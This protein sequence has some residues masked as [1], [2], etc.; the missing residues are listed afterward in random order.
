MKQDL[1]DTTG[2]KQGSVVLPDELF[3][4]K[5][6]SDL[7][8]RYIR[9]FLSRN[10]QAT[11]QTKRR[12][13]LSGTTAKIW[14]QKGTGKA[15]HGS[16]KASI[17]VGGAKAH[18]PTGQENYQLKFS[19]K[20]KKQA[21]ASSLSAM[22]PQTKIIKGL[23]QVSKTTKTIQQALENLQ[24]LTPG[25]LTTIILSNSSSPIIKVTS[26]LDNVI[27]TQAHRVNPYEILNCQHLI[28]T[29][30]SLETLTKTFSAKKPVQP[31]KVTAKKS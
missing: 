27:T 23:D 12:N 11:K 9:I 30:E 13:Q 16:R 10:R 31:T 17:F 15:R 28:I 5:V 19:K 25:K 29:Q 2:K 7:L 20:Q 24:S 3:A 6:S 8:S 21:L 14:R 18:G 4:V 1:F 22:L 26:N